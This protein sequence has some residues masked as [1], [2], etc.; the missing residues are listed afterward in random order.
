MASERSIEMRHGQRLYLSCGCRV[1]LRPEVERAVLMCFGALGS[2]EFERKAV[3]E[4]RCESSEIVW[5]P[6][7]ERDAKR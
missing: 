5:P 3:A 7:D 4:H 1:Y 2:I 6:L